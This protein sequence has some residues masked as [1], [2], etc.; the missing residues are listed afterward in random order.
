MET[1]AGKAIKYRLTQEMKETKGLKPV[2]TIRITFEKM[3]QDGI[4]NE[5]AYFNNA[6]KTVMNVFDLED[7]L[8]I[9]TERFKQDYNMNISVLR[10]DNQICQWT[11]DKYC[12]IQCCKKI[13]IHQTSI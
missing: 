5:T 10:M 8:I 9:F 13:F 1:E 12:A 2:E 3:S 4:S 7:D 11:L 6:P